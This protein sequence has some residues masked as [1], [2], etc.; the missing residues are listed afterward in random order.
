MRFFMT[1]L[2]TIFIL[3]FLLQLPAVQAYELSDSNLEIEKEMSLPVTLK[4]ENEAQQN[5][6]T[7]VKLKQPNLRNC[8]IYK[9]QGHGFTLTVYDENSGGQFNKNQQLCLESWHGGEKVR[10]EDLLGVGKQFILIETEGEKGDDA[11]SNDLIALA[12]F[13]GKFKTLLF[14]PI[15]SKGGS[16]G[17]YQDLN[18][19]YKFTK[20]KKGQLVLDIASTYKSGYEERLKINFQS[21]WTD[22][23]IFDKTTYSFYDIGSECGKLQYA[24]FIIQ[25]N[26]AKT[27]LLLFNRDIDINNQCRYLNVS[28]ASYSYFFLLAGTEGMMHTYTPSYMERK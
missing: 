7:I 19:K 12:W 11:S 2:T 6:C 24:P 17:F 20:D 22:R 13:K 9:N 16:L 27:R 8:V 28:P 14:E 1:L 5:N 26:I 3:I 10:Y 4:D 15:R 25:S 21:S 23:F 18:V